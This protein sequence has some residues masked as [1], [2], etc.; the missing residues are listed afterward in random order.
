MREMA[1][2]AHLLQL[3]GLGESS[4]LIT[5]GRYSGSNYGICIGHVSPEAADGGPLAVVQDGDMI[6]IDI[7]KRSIELDISDD[8]LRERLE[9]WQPP[10]PKYEKGILSWYSRNVTSSA[11][12]AVLKPRR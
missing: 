9:A 12:G 4:A 10:R 1:V 8:L 5:D 2:P 6:E 7:S 3:L 11:K